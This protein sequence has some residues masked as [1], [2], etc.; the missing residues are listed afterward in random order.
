[1][2]LQRVAIELPKDTENRVEYIELELQK[3]GIPLRWY[4]V[5]SVK[6]DTGY[7]V[8]VEVVFD[9]SDTSQKSLPSYSSVSEKS[10]SSPVIV[11][12]VPTG[13]GASVG[14][15]LGDAMPV[16]L[17]LSKIGTLVTHPNSCNGGPLLLA[18][19]GSLQYVEG[20]T[21]DEWIK[22]NLSLLPVK[23]NQKIGVVLDSGADTWTIDRAVNA[24]NGFYAHTGSSIVAIQK[25]A[26]P[27]NPIVLKTTEGA[28]TG[29]V[30]NIE[31]IFEA[32]EKLVEKGANRI[33]LFTHVKVE[34]NDWLEYFKGNVPNPVGGVE[35]LM[36]HLIT[37][38]FGIMSAHGPLVSQEE[39]VFI[40]S[41]GRVLPEAALEA[42]SPFYLWCVLRGLQDSPDIFNYSESTNLISSNDVS[43]VICPASSL[44][45]IPMLKAE[46]LGKPILAV[47]NNNT[48]LN[49]SA[50]ML[51]MENVIEIESFVHV[52]GLLVKAKEAGDF[53]LN[54]LRN[55]LV[56]YPVYEIGELFL[57]SQGIVPESVMRPSITIPFYE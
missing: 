48:V 40:Q 7:R 41:V 12:I 52:A 32:V 42:A 38:R 51:G 18:D 44:G 20:Y 53:S 6:S 25:T 23:N 55:I 31:T 11:H 33:A 54:N 26:V 24:I 21:L 43:V 46:E 45:G 34:N 14:G 10:N 56:E 37:K 9:S 30:E 8:A 28:F 47:K 39:E 19:Q 22:G 5:D 1:M 16:N 17:F 36:S 50:G 13:I 29:K 35:A 49:V 4:I 3:I 27:V 2:N 57:Q 15:S